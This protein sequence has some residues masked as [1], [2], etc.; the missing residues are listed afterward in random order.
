MLGETEV[1]AFIVIGLLIILATPILKAIIEH[2]I[3]RAKDMQAVDKMKGLEF[4]LFLFHLFK[5]L[6]YKVQQT[7][8]SN[9][10]GVDLILKKDNE[11]IAVQAK[12]YKNKVNLKAVQEV[13][14]G[15]A[16]YNATQAWVVTNSFYADSAVKLAH[17]NDVLLIDRYGLIKLMK[18]QSK[19]KSNVSAEMK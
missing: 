10:Y 19:V 12:R 6:G 18:K 15:R 14:S 8:A 5:A 3:Y 13:V 17:S 4:E 1:K 9:D 11:V 7:K 2:K 16:Y